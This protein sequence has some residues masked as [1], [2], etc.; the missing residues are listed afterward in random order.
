MSAVA[1]IFRREFA[2]YFAT[3]IAFV[4][5]SSSCSRWACSLL[6]RSFLRQ[7]RRRPVGVFRLP[8]LALSVSNP[9]LR[10]GSGPKKG[11]AAASNCC[12]PALAGLGA[13]LGKFLAAWAF[14]GWRWR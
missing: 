2:A 3:P 1:A 4:F 12:S 11:A 10:C 6:Y 9:A 13:V 5:S 8:A 14:A 7:W